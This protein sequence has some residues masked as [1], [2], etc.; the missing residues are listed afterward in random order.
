MKKYIC[1]SVAELY[2][3]LY[4]DYKAGEFETINP[5]G[6]ETKE[7]I[8][9]DIMITNPRNRIAYN[10]D[11]NFS[12][13][14]AFI[15][16]LMIFDSSNELKYFSKFNSN[17]ANF[18]DDGE[19]LFGSYGYR[20]AEYIPQI[21]SKLKKDNASRQ[22]VLPILRAKDVVTKTK[23]I[24]CTL[25][26][27][28]LI[29]NNKLN[30]IVN[31]RSNDIIWGVPYD[32]FVFTT[33]QEI[34]ANTLGIELGWYIHRPASL[35]IYETHYELFEKVGVAG[36]KNVEIELPFNY[37][38]WMTIKSNYMKNIDNDKSTIINKTIF[39]DVY[40]SRIAS[41]LNEVR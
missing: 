15:E 19:T 2:S 10:K 36:F 37:A 11:R 5:R 25:S 34:I 14:Y 26:L 17:I 28:L 23:D 21:I 12:T 33:I 13:M 8:A 40:K 41:K 32:I 31:M 3:K 20:I 1:N 39:G 16:S 29:R 22:M 7:M 38:D 24:P 9:P 6:L 4:D 18:S 35:H 27:Q 30:M